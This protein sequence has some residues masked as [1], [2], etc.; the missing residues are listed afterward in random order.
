MAALVQTTDTESFQNWL[1]GALAVFF[2]KQG[3]QS[4]V[5][6]ELTQ[7]QRDLLTSIFKN[8][9]LPIG[10]TCTNCTTENVL[11][12]PTQNFCTKGQ[13]CNM[14]D[15]SIPDKTPKPCPNNICHDVK[16]AIRREHR[17]N[18]PSWKNTNA[19]GWCTNVIEIAKCYMPPDGYT[20]V[21]TI[22]D[23]DFNGILTVIL[24]NKRF[25]SK[26]TAP[27]NS[28]VNVCTE[29][30]EVSRDTR[31][32][33][34]L[35]ISDTNLARYIDIL[36]RLLSDPT[37]LA[38]DQNAKTAVDKLNQLKS[39]TLTITTADIITVLDSKLKDIIQEQRDSVRDISEEKRKAKEDIEDKKTKAKEDIEDKRTQANE[40]IED[41]KKQFL[42]DVKASLSHM[43]TV[44]T[45]SLDKIIESKQSALTE[46]QAKAENE[47]IVLTALS[48]TEKQQI[49]D[50]AEKEKDEFNRVVHNAKQELTA[51]SSQEEKHLKEEI[52]K[53]TEFFQTLYYYNANM[54]K[55]K[56]LL[57]N[58]C[59]KEGLDHWTVVHNGG[60]GFDC[61]EEPIGCVKIY[62]CPRVKG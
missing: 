2:A 24:N 21:T 23:T 28:R 35:T 43:R 52:R 7:F 54:P 17:Y 33:A 56:N 25:E 50:A 8:K 41:K 58:P 48:R 30:R 55:S 44:T 4:F 9:N 10:T 5:V 53:E 15:P 39:N 13:K 14:H 57:R 47:R 49:K 61:E 6:D 26:M 31:H 36:I 27:L 34:N 11:Y 40:G 38:A 12:C 51:I 42:G 62:D 3:L 16:D 32:S 19:K 45:S 18:G 59:A 37:C 46:I 29:A 20:N 60:D 22:T 1:R